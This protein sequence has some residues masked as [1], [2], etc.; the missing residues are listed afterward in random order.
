MSMCRFKSAK[1]A[2]YLAFKAALEDYLNSITSNTVETQR[3]SIQTR[4][5][6]DQHHQFGAAEHEGG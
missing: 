6:A 2:G 1:V 5:A 3:T 4:T